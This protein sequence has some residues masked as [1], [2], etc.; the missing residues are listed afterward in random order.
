MNRRTLVKTVAAG[1]AGLLVAGASRPGW[2][3]ATLGGPCDSCEAIDDGQPA[4]LDATAVLAGTA[5]PGERLVVEGRILHRAGA[6]PAAGVVLY[7]W[8]T[9]AAGHY[10]TIPG[11]RGAAARH[12]A[13]RGWLRTGSDGRY[14]IETIRP[15]SYPGQTMPAHIHAVVREPG[16]PYYYI[17]D[18]VFDDDPLLTAAG[19]RHAE[20]RGGSGILSLQHEDG[21]WHGRRDIRLGL[22]IPGYPEDA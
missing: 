21:R 1:I 18:F 20:G 13:L 14:R 22:R 19:R 17:D 6:M 16:R 7:L 4:A 5:E 10:R 9:D 15:A 2:A 3:A 8:Q 11:Q 12:G